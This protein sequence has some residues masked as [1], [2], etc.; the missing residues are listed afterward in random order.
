MGGQFGASNIYVMVKTLRTPQIMVRVPPNMD[1][2]WIPRA[3]KLALPQCPSQ[4]G[5]VNAKD[6][7]HPNG[8]VSSLRKKK[9][10]RNSNVPSMNQPSPLKESSITPVFLFNAVFPC[11]FPHAPVCAL[12]T[13]PPIGSSDQLVLS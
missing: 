1:Q 4:R 3:F 13:S 6:G 9:T 2:V 12:P 5:A 10:R 11:E 8:C 7:R